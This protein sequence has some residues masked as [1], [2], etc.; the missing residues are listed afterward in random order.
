MDSKTKKW[1]FSGLM[2]L[3]GT[4]WIGMIAALAA[5]QQKMVFN[6]SRV[7]EV[8]RPRSN[9]HRTRAVV[10]RSSDGTRLCGWFLTPNAPGTHP[11]VIYFG[12]RSEEVSW[13]ARD[14]GTLFPGMAVLVINYRGYGDSHG[15]PGERQM[16]EDGQMLYDWMATHRHIDP[17]RIA[18]VGRSLGSG[19][20]IQVAVHRPAAALALITPY[21][22]ILAIARRRFRGMPISLL[23]KHRFESIKH[24]E[25]VSAPVL[26]LR[27]ES[28]DVVPHAHTDLLV[29]KLSTV[30]LDEVVPASDHCDIP[31]L[32]ET[33]KRIAQ[34][35]HARF[36]VT[37]ASPVQ[38]TNATSTEALALNQGFAPGAQ[39]SGL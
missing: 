35:L 27:A 1:V 32:E 24:A 13:V 21:D 39:L 36:F 31:Y 20:A 5:M 25:K 19:V 38:V 23:L 29:S 8:E 26:I 14:A 17:A 10:L 4:G 15:N 11:G 22:S 6:P 9:G 12:G 7:K 33:Q 18:V 28:D 37:L 3:A 34:F 30:V 2:G 16:I